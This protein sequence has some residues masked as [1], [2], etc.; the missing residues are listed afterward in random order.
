[1]SPFD[2]QIDRAAKYLR[3]TTQA[4]RR[5]TPWEQ[6]PKASKKKWT[7]LAAGVL[8]AAGS[9]PASALADKEQPK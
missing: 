8:V 2:D 3:D 1:M 5:L 7:A 6:T 4:G 9:I